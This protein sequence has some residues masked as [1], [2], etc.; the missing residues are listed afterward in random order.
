[1]ES[2]RLEAFSDGVM[3]IIIT[4]TVLGVRVPEEPTLAALLGVAP[5]LAIYAW[6]F[7]TV[8]TYWNNHHHLLRRAKHV[9]PAIMWANLHLLFWLSLIP[10][11]TEWLG[12]HIAAPWP[13]AAYAALL[14]FA[15]VAYNI[16][17][18]AIIAAEGEDSD[19]AR[20]IGRDWKDK[21]SLALYACAVGAA[22]VLPWVSY[23]LAVLVQAIWFLPDPRVRPRAA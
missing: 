4:I 3:A 14:F 11:A 8:G 17:Q 2:S 18:Q 9:S 21:I 15:A 7:Q 10:F 1:M 13:T 19:I 22:F 23:A 5:V 12:R 6:S 20:D 16:L